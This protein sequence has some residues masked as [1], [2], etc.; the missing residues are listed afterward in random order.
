VSTEFQAALDKI[1]GSLATIA[2]C[3]DEERQRRHV[4]ERAELAH[5]RRFAEQARQN[6]Y[7]ADMA[8]ARRTWEP[9]EGDRQWHRE[10]EREMEASARGLAAFEA[11]HP[12]LRD[13][14]RA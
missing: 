3:M 7:S 2:A 5:L 13:E 9:S 8:A 14:V 11:A 6:F 1:A 10:A 12:W 4:S